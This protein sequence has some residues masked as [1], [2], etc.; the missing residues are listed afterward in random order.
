M[1]CR[2]VTAL[3]LVSAVS[4]YLKELPHG[5]TAHHPVFDRGRM[6]NVAL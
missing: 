2:A 3:T 1:C 4:E 5:C 6:K